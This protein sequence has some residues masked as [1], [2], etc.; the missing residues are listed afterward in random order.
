MTSNLKSAK[1]A[2]QAELS[3]AREGVTY[4]T[5]RVEALEIALL[6]LENVEGSDGTGT[7]GRKSAAESAAGAHR[8][9]PGRPAG[10]NAQAQRSKN[11]AHRTKRRSRRDSAGLPATG[12]DFWLKLVSEQPKSAVDISNAAAEALGIDA[13]QKEQIQ[14]LKQRVSPALASL[15]SAHKIQDSGAGRERRFF[16]SGE[17]R[18]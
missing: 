13:D 2:I 17:Q 5:A 15:L 8:A 4:Y 16:K 14:K 18:A 3:H 7:R 9:K 1:Q 11:S 10:K 12:G 6:Q